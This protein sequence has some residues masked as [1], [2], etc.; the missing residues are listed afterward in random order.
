MDNREQALDVSYDPRMRTIRWAAATAAALLLTGC[1]ADTQTSPVEASA[2]TPAA[3]DGTATVDEYA[4]KI[5][6][7][8]GTVDDWV[9]TWDDSGC[10]STDLTSDPL[11]NAYAVTGSLD[12]IAAG[13]AV[14]T[15]SKTGA[16]GYVGDPPAEVAELY[17]TTLTAA[18]AALDAGEK[19][20]GLDC[21]ESDECSAALLKVHGAMRTLKSEFSKWTPYY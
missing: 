8:H 10:T 7:L 19:Y 20:S 3:A 18:D 6:E 4:A 14:G 9:S 17:A 5:S 21:P 11:C 1:G 13:M 12:A 15:L 16:P 2:T